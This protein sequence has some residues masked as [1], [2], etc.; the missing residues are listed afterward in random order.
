M[1]SASYID[2]IKS[3]HNLTTDYQVCKKLGITT[4]RLA[5]YRKGRSEFADDIIPRVAELTGRDAL[6]VFLDVNL[7]RANSEFAKKAFKQLAELAS[8][9][10]ANNAT[11]TQTK[12]PRNA[13]SLMVAGDGIEPPTRGFSIPCSTD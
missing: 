2:A 7:S 1:K 4:S 5:S 10:A 8:K 6:E 12:K 11:S 9:N 13:G 3:R